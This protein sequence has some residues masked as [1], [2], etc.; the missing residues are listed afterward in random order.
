MP[1]KPAYTR[2]KI[3]LQC[4]DEV[5]EEKWIRLNQSSQTIR[6]TPTE[7][8]RGMAQISACLYYEGNF[9]NKTVGCRIKFSNKIIETEFITFRN[10]LEP[11]EK[12]KVK[13]TLK[14]HKS[15]PVN[16]ELLCAMYDASLDAFAPNRFGM[17]FHRDYWISFPTFRHSYSN[18]SYG[19]L[20]GHQ[21]QL[22]LGPSRQGFPEWRF[23]SSF[24]Y[25]YRYHRS[26]AES[27]IRFVPGRPVSKASNLEMVEESSLEGMSI[28]YDS[29]QMADND[30]DDE[31]AEVT[32][33]FSSIQIQEGQPTMG[34][35]E[36]EPI[37]IRENF[38]ETAFFLPFLRTET[39]SSNTPFPKV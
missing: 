33:N 4:N 24:P 37:T 35:S 32:A 10:E 2:V 15:K 19:T 27:N 30:V 20:S 23:S 22:Y 11:G 38:A 25:G 7:K 16:A 21:C 34:T 29:Q 26:Y 14:D 39:S 9:Y 3:L 36:N 28:V 6:F 18:M 17:S 31:M 1:T 8:Q 13:L 5:I 12:T